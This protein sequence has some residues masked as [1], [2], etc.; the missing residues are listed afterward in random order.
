[1]KL[2]Q[3]KFQLLSCNYQRRFEISKDNAQDSTYANL[4]EKDVKVEKVGDKYQYTFKVKEANGNSLITKRTKYQFSKITHNGENIILTDQGNK[5]KEAVLTTDKLLDKIQLKT[6]VV[7]KQDKTG[8]E[9]DT[10]LAL[11]FPVIEKP[12]ADSNQTNNPTNNNPNNNNATTNPV[13]TPTAKPAE[14]QNT[15]SSVKP[16]ST[17]FESAIT[18]PTV[19]KD[20]KPLIFLYWKIKRSTFCNRKLRSK[21][22][23]VAVD[24]KGNKLVVLTIKN[25]SYWKEFKVEGQRVTT[26]ARDKEHDTR[27]VAFPYVKG[28]KVYNAFV[29]IEVPKIGYKGNYDI[30]IINDEP[31]KEFEPIPIPKKKTKS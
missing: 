14:T 21:P 9:V 2:K 8:N 11:D 25:D 23:K 19:L 26:I 27:T 24:E 28:Q 1:M 16:N 22:I 7:S 6:T 15:T 13:E 31:N 18:T 12:K 17:E 20:E 3:L 29:S 4:F 10:T 30:R 5:V